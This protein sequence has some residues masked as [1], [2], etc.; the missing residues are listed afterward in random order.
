MLLPAFQVQRNRIVNRWPGITMKKADLP[1]NLP[2]VIGRC[3]QKS[4]PTLLSK[5]DAKIEREEK[6]KKKGVK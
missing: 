5:P 6:K 3:L 2:K 4:G 1:G